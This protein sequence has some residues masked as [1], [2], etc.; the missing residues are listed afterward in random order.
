MKNSK[1]EVDFFC[2]LRTI[3]KEFSAEFPERLKDYLERSEIFNTLPADYYE[4]LAKMERTPADI[5]EKL[6]QEVPESS[7][8]RKYLGWVEDHSSPKK[9]GIV[10]SEAA[11]EEIP[12][13]FVN[14]TRDFDLYVA[15]NYIKHHPEDKRWE[16]V[17]THL[18]GMEVAVSCEELYSKFTPSHTSPDYNA[19]LLWVLK[20]CLV[21]SSLHKVLAKP[22]FLTELLKFMLLGSTETI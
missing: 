6:N 20:Q 8:F 10:D 4:A 16:D 1:G 5:I 3:K 15:I 22:A 18:K 7:A 11:G 13:E 12:K 2:Y 14:S 9:P 19:S 21:S 17:Q